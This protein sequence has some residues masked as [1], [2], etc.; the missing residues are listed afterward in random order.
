MNELMNDELMINYSDVTNFGKVSIFSSVDR[1]FK[2][3]SYF[4]NFKKAK[5]KRRRNVV[6]TF[7]TFKINRIPPNSGASD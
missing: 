7:I 2:Q 6:T 3:P 4:L 1:I 5:F